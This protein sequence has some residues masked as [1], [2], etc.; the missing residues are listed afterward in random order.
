M[1]VAAGLAALFCDLVHQRQDRIA[2]DI[3]LARAADRNRARRHR[4]EPRSPPPP[5]PGSR[6]SAPRPSPARF[7]PRRSARSGEDRKTPRAWQACRRHRGTGRNRGRWSR[8]G[9]RAWGSSAAVGWRRRSVAQT[10]ALV[11]IASIASLRHPSGLGAPC[12]IAH[13]A[14]YDIAVVVRPRSRGATR[15]SLASPSA[16]V[17]R[18]RRESRV[19]AA[20]AVSCAKC[21]RKRTRAYRFSG[22]NPA[23][24]AQWFTAYFELSPVTGLSCHRRPEKLASRET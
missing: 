9:K 12:A 3:G 23:F 18:G 2:D 21:K 22:G 7:R 11:V 10:Q 24:P 17:R 16:L 14:R 1:H 15:P 19:R 6:R 13:Q 5:P 20:P 4:C 8:A